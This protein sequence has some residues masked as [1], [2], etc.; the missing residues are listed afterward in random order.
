VAAITDAMAAGAAPAIQ[1]S[2]MTPPARTASPDRR[3]VLALG[4]LLLA[5]GAGAQP[6]G[7]R[8]ERP[9]WNHTVTVDKGHGAGPVLQSA[10][11]QVA[12][13]GIGGSATAQVLKRL[14][15]YVEAEVGQKGHVALS[16][17][18]LVDAA[19][20]AKAAKWS[21]EDMARLVIAL[22]RQFD[23]TRPEEVARLQRVV[24]QVRQGSA[25]DQILGTGETLKETRPAR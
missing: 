22:Q 15:E 7:L 24:D 11:H 19:S 12:A 8:R 3:L 10:F 17:G 4:L 20:A 2:S 13:T 6:P 16:M 14:G 25:P 23:Q 18:M 9:D 5:A 1:M 21:T